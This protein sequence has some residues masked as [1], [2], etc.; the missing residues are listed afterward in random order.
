[1]ARF[2][3]SAESQEMRKGAAHCR[4]QYVAYDAISHMLG[5]TTA[6]SSIESLTAHLPQPGT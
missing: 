6:A 1:M 2:E 4:L 3:T 5:G